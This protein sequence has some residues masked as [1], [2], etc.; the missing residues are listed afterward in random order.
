MMMKHDNLP[1]SGKVQ[2][3]TIQK[4]V[5]PRQRPDERCARSTRVGTELSFV[6]ASLCLHERIISGAS[7]I[8]GVIESKEDYRFY[9]EADR[10]ALNIDSWWPKYF[11]HDIW[12]FERHLRRLEY[13]KNCRR[14]P[15]WR[16]IYYFLYWRFRRLSL[17]LGFS[18]PPNVFG[19]GLSIAHPG[20]LIV[21]DAARIGENC[22]VHPGVTIGTAAGET[23]AAPRIGDNAFIG[24]NAVIIGPIE[25]ADDCAIG[26]NAVVNRSFTEP[27]I[28]I[29]GV[30]ARKVSSKGS[31]GLYQRST[32]L[33]RQKRR[34][35]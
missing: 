8:V 7:D 21:N 26:A 2:S 22:R 1:N 4:W 32:H 29:A 28:T 6:S 12:R 5:S 13:W 34:D 9:L 10:V 17:R 30:P 11:S 16:P 15:V 20:T 19:P 33:V 23:H 24:P 3:C 31:K 14:S 25:I 27:G 18:I 35:R